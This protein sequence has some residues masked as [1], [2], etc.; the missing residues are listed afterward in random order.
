MRDVFCY[1]YNDVK[2]KAP[3][4]AQALVEEIRAAGGNVPNGGTH[5]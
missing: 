3:R 4:D 5:A 2:V 1:F